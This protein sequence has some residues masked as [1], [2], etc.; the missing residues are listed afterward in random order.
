[1]LKKLM[2]A[3]LAVGA[4]SLN[5]PAA[6]ASHGQA[7]CGF[8]SLAQETAT[9]GQDTYSG[10]A[11]GYVASPTPGEAVEVQCVIEVNGTPVSSTP[12]GTGTNFATTAGP[13]SF[14]AA[15]TDTVEICTRW[16]VGDEQENYVCVGSTNTQIPP[17]EILDAL[18]AVFEATG[19][20]DFLLCPLLAGLAPG[21]PGVVD[22]DSEGD[23]S[24][25]GT[26]FWDC[27]PYGV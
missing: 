10:G 18:D 3:S 24:I 12:T 21:V 23:V 2:I 22:I 13:I 8:D 17:Q 1:M 6:L 15:D 9:G 4:L 27:P 19:A 25:A 14:T 7:D 20:V 26:P 16:K 5:A 11:Y